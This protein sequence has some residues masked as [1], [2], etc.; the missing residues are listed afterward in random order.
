ML[1]VHRNAPKRQARLQMFD[2]RS[3][4]WLK[5]SVSLAAR[6]ITTSPPMWA[7]NITIV[8]TAINEI[9]ISA[10]ESAANQYF[11]IYVSAL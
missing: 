3:A 5:G 4:V 9:D 8:F 1:K 6:M 7:C 2:P 10:A 11:D